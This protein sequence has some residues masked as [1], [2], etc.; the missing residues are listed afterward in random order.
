MKIK[1]DILHLNNSIDAFCLDK[2]YK[3]SGT[4]I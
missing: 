3:K 1:I 4:T 2:Y